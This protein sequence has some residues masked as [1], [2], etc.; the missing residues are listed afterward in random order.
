MRFRTR[1]AAT[2]LVGSFA[3]LHAPD[4]QAQQAAQKLEYGITAGYGH[5]DN[6]FRRSDD[7]IASDILQAGVEL[8]WQEDRTRID[9]NVRADLDFNHYLN[10]DDDFDVDNQLTGNAQGQVTLGIVPEHFTWFI[11][12]SLGQT[13][14]DP[15]VPATPETMETT[16]YL[17]TGPDFTILIGSASLLRFS[18]RYS[19]TDYEVSPFDSTRT[20]GGITFQRNVSERSTLALGVDTDDVDYDDDTNLDFKR[21]NASVNYTLH[22][23]RTDIDATFGYTQMDIEDGSEKTGPLVEVEVRR[24]VSNSSGLNLRFGTMLSD[25]AEAL[26]N[27][28]ESGDIGND[29][30]GVIATSATFENKF[31]SLAW[32]FDR[33]RTSFDVSVGW[34]KDVYDTVDDLDRERMIFQAGAERHLNNRLS[35][36]IRLAYDEETYET[37]DSEI[38]ELRLILGGSWRFG[39]D[40]GV[41]VW[42]ERLKRDSNTLAGGGNSLENRVFVTFFYRPAAR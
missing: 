34:D 41:D 30:V 26:R 13:Q 15:L 12:D 8:N 14:Q 35:A 31:A 3:S 39:R 33:P 29:D 38:E 7:E 5:S 20:G 17:T 42:G 6:V 4:A 22:A 27:E 37:D 23:A 24:Q 10:V 25:S 9:A 19:A 36:H 1:L 21:Q 18:G 28:L 40:T 2:A 16:N 11:E 32:Q